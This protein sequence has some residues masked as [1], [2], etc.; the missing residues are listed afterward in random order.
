[1]SRRAEKFHFLPFSPLSLLSSQ[2]IRKLA[3]A[4]GNTILLICALSGASQAQP[5]AQP[6]KPQ[7]IHEQC[8]ALTAGKAADDAVTRAMASL[9]GK[10]TKARTEAAQQLG[11]SC[12]SRA[13]DPLIES[14]RDEDP[15]IRIAAVEALGKLGDP[16]SVDDLIEL[17]FDSDWR[18]RMALIGTM[19]S[20]KTFKARNTVLNGI[21]NPNGADITDEN[22]MR[23]RCAAILTVNQLRDVQYS[24]KAILFLHFFL[25]SKHENIRRMAEQTMYEL[26]NTRNGA[27]ELFALLK[28]YNFFQIRRWAAYWI[29]RLGIESGR[30]VLQNAAANDPDPSVQRVAADA[31]KQLPAVK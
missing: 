21:A 31:L 14:L 16:V 8:P 10:D 20:F 15:L 25:E 12:D 9:K 19:A 11:Q 29:G 3:C 18:V 1:M 22:D 6:I 4:G 30:E 27:T 26:K 13:V 28:Q 7:P 24:R 2:T 5:Q 17:I 23:V